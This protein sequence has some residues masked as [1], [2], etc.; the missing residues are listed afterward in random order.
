MTVV[1]MRPL[2]SGSRIRA[3]DPH[4]FS[5]AFNR[6]YYVVKEMIYGKCLKKLILFYPL[7]F[8]TAKFSKLIAH[9]TVKHKCLKCVCNSYSN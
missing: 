4:L 9:I 5:A 6:F 1:C 8:I 7:C 3:A 2:Y